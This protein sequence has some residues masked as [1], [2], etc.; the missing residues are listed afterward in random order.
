MFEYDVGRQCL[1]AEGWCPTESLNDVQNALT[2]GSVNIFL[3]FFCLI[4]FTFIY[5]FI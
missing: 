5:L 1:I 4:F 3:I 2:I